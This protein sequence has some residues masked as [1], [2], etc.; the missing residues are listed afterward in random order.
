MASAYAAFAADG[1]FCPPVP[2]TAITDRRNKPLPAPPS[3]CRQAVEED[4][5]HGVTY[6]LER[7]LRGGGTASNVGGISG[8]AS[9][10]KTGTTDRSMDTW[11][12]GYTKQRT[13]AVW[14]GDPTLYSNGKRKPLQDRSIN[15]DYRSSW[16]GA[17]LAAPIWKQIMKTAVEGTSDAGWPS[18]PSSM[19]GAP[20]AP[21]P[22]PTKGGVPG[23][24][25]SSVA[26]AVAALQQA[27]YAVRVS[28]QPVRSK[29][30]RGT[31]AGTSPRSGSG[32]SPGSTVTIFISDGKAGKGRGPGR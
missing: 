18:P 12:V 9:A 31:V 4:V 25:G 8:W 5:A 19:L 7:V 21:K 30:P 15:G 1:R 14:V 11:F 26:A 3:K 6:A 10:G 29:Y 13:T 24:A 22:T 16:Y 27:G 28:P 2:V 17:S 32:A 20:R 23:V